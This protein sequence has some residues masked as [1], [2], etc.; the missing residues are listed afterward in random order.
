M[1]WELQG[2]YSGGKLTGHGS[3]MPI[4][5]FNVK[6]WHPTVSRWWHWHDALPY[7]AFRVR[8][9]LVRVGSERQVARRVLA[10]CHTSTLHYLLSVELPKWSTQLGVRARVCVLV[11]VHACMLAMYAC[12]A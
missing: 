7:S 11:R 3:L 9:S 1:D 2:N 12:V 5:S 10:K 6:G 8:T 4:Y